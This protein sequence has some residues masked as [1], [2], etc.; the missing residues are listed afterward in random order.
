VVEPCEPLLQL[1]ELQRRERER[2]ATSRGVAL[3]V[4]PLVAGPAVKR[5][6]AAMLAGGTGNLNLASWPEGEVSG[7]DVEE[8]LARVR[9]LLKF[10]VE[11]RGPKVDKRA[12]IKKSDLM[13]ERW[14]SIFQ[15]YDSEGN[16]TLGLED[17][18]RM[19]RR[20]LK[21]AERL[22]SD[23]QLS[24]LFSAIDEDG[25]GSVEF[26]EFLEFVQQPGKKGTTST[27]EVVKQV[28]RAV[29]LALRRNKIHVRELEQNFHQF[30]ESGDI[31]TGEL[32]PEEMIRF[33]RRVLTVTKHECSD[34]NLRIAFYAMDDDGSGT[35][36]LGEFMDFIKFCNNDGEEKTLP[37][38][39][40]GLLGG[41]RGELPSR[42]PR[43]R[44]GTVSGRPLAQLPFCLN[45][46]DLPS[47]SRIVSS[48]R[49]IISSQ[50]EPGLHTLGLRT[51]QARSWA[52][53]SAASDMHHSLATDRSLTSPSAGSLTEFSVDSS[54]R[55]LKRPAQESGSGGIA[56]YKMLKGGHILNKIEQ[57]LFEAGIDVRGNYHRLR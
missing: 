19:V 49:K 34:K 55:S 26:N 14:K 8:M 51:S 41:M 12:G 22:V 45:G 21:I 28:A 36:S 16:G 2:I 53:S 24:E 17:I 23:H 30:D 33:F 42:L 18:R 25:G 39:V 37:L 44:P 3:L 4:A 31:A 32:G 46:R 13:C 5:R 15:K 11:N 6:G 9:S 40:P 48:G 35:M 56:G 10:S 50:S 47:A 29:R 27:E 43:H 57:S 20:D 52:T 7:D 38:R 1:A 54:P